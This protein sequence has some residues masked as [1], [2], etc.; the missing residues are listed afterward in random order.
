MA[1]LH[2]SL[3]LPFLYPVLFITD[4]SKVNLASDSLE[5]KL[6]SADNWDLHL[7]NSPTPPQVLHIGIRVPEHWDS[8]S[9]DC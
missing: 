7:P 8:G 9:S 3:T 2:L 6:F 1:I 5:I 4:S